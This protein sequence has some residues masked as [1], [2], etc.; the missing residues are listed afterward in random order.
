[1]EGKELTAAAKVRKANANY[2]RFRHAVG[3]GY[4]GNYGNEKDFHK[5]LH[6]YSGR[7]MVHDDETLELDMKREFEYCKDHSLNVIKTNNYGNITSDLKTE[8]EFVVNPNVDNIY[9]G[10]EGHRRIDEDKDIKGVLLLDTPILGLD[11]KLKVLIKGITA[12][13]G[14]CSEENVKIKT[15]GPN[16]KEV[17]LL[18]LTSVRENFKSR[19]QGL[20]NYQ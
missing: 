4:E 9:P 16:K 8:W 17:A 7:P 6:K 20:W 14:S 12:T 10:Q 18:Q 2:R 3:W 15:E 1:M 5:G 19:F 13:V 11:S